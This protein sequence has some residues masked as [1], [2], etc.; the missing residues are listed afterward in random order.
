MPF[1]TPQPVLHNV[2]PARHEKAKEEPAEHVEDVEV[3]SEG[4]TNSILPRTTKEDDLPFI[5]SRVVKKQGGKGGGR[6]CTYLRTP[7]PQ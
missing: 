6:L 5:P 2:E 7:P 1:F 3:K 4:I